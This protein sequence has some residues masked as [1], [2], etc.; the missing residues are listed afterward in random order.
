MFDLLVA[1]KWALKYAVNAAC[2][3]LRVRSLSITRIAI[4]FMFSVSL[5]W[6]RS[7][8]Q[9]VLEVLSPETRAEEWT[10]TMIR[11]NQPSSSEL[12][13]SYMY[14]E[15]FEYV[16]VDRGKYVFKMKCR[17]NAIVLMKPG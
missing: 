13:H 16:F 2:T 5:R 6:T 17:S 14:C 1:K 12:L 7:S 10:K 4:V 8:W 3:I 15:N 9:S 11:S